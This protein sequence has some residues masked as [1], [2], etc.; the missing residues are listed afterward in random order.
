LTQSL[1]VMLSPTLVNRKMTFDECSRIGVY[2]LVVK[3]S[4]LLESNLHG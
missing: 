4:F 1:L 3:G 2:R